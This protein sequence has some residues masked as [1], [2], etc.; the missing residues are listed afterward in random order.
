[1]GDWDQSEGSSTGGKFYRCD[2]GLINFFEHLIGLSYLKSKSWG[3]T[4]HPTK[5][6]KAPV[7]LLEIPRRP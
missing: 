7:P 4:P 5:R 3:F 2:L 6:G 1:M